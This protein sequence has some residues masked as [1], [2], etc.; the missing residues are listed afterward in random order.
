VRAGRSA[1]ERD[2]VR[3]HFLGRQEGIRS[4]LAAPLLKTD[5]CVCAAAV[6]FVRAPISHA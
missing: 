1:E 4:S 5:N 6:G 2:H 3:C